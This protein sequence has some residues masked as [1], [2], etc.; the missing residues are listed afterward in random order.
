MLA[1]FFRLLFQQIAL[2]M[3]THGSWKVDRPTTTTTATTTTTTTTTKAIQQQGWLVYERAV[4][5]PRV[6]GG[7]RGQ[8]QSELSVGKARTLL[9]SRSLV[10]TQPGTRKTSF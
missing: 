8:A 7:A 6:L 10:S 9:Q 2:P 1:A 3:S 4:Q 5:M